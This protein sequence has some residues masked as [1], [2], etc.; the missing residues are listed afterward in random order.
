MDKVS[1]F[2]NGSRK[3]DIHKKKVYPYAL[4]HKHFDSKCM[5]DFNLRLGTLKLLEKNIGKS[6]C[7]IGTGEDGL[8]GL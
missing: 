4:P 5:K 2:K 3:P 6:R 1:P 8:K 7:D